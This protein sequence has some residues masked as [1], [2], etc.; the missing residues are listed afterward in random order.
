MGDEYAHVIVS[1]LTCLDEDS[2]ESDGSVEP[3]ET[4]TMLVSVRF[5]EKIMVHL[6]QVCI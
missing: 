2:D 3:M 5:I 1:C 6:E 4:D